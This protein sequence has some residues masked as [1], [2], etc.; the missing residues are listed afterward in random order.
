MSQRPKSATLSE[1]IDEVQAQSAVKRCDQWREEAIRARVLAA[2]GRPTRM[3]KVSVLPLWGDH[4]RVNVWIAGSAGAAIPNSYF[5]TAD[6]Q[7]AILQSEPPIQ[8]QY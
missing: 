4:F 8:K 2:L 7:G 1:V 3:V 5:V 6:D